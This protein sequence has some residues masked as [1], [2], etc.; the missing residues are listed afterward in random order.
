[1]KIIKE[2]IALPELIKMAES[3]Y[4]NLVKAVV[5]IRR[6]IMAVDAELHSDEEAALLESGSRQE[7]LWGINIYTGLD[8]NAPDF[9]EFDSLINLRPRQNNR[10][11]GVED[12]AVREKITALVRKRVA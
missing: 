3:M 1:M 2:N 4:G 11:R 10:S 12:P 8:R 9:I 7:D 6:E 5:D